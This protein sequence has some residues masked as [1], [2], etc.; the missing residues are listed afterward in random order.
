MILTKT[1]PIELHKRITPLMDEY[2]PAVQG[3]VLSALAARFIA[4]MRPEL[5]DRALVKFLSQMREYLE[6]DDA[7]AP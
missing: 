1:D 4:T 2:H 5:R 6:T 3:A 7:P